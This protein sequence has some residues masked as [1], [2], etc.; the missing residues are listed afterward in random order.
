MTEQKTKE[1]RLADYVRIMYA[2]EEQMKDIREAK[3]DTKQSYIDN[4]WLT[5]EDIKLAMKISKLIDEDVKLEEI[6]EVYK[7][8]LNA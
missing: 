8:L 2:Y 3:K 7:V 5:K 6:E 1:Q 4:N